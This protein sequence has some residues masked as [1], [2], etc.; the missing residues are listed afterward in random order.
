MSTVR[1]YLKYRGGYHDKCG[2]YLKYR[3]GAQYRGVILSTVGEYL[4][5]RGGDI[6]S[7]V[8]YS[9]YPSMLL[10]ISLHVTEHPHGTEHPPPPPPPPPTIL[11]TH[12]AG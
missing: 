7:T 4:D 2:G 9:R 5:A 3:G 1:G 10:M 12:Y 11:N 8:G 6:M